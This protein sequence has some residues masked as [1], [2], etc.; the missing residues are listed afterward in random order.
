MKKKMKITFR[1]IISI[2]LS[3]ALVVL[4]FS[5]AQTRSEE[6]RLDE[7]LHLR[8]AVI[9]KS[10]KETIEAF[11][12][13]TEDAG[14][15]Q[16]FVEKFQGHKRLTG[17]IVDLKDK[18]RIALP[19]E[20]A[21]TDLFQKES[22]QTI[23]DN[24]STEV[25]SKWKNSNVYFYSI[26]LVKEGAVVGSLGLI[27]D[28]TFIVNQIRGFWKRS[29][30]TFSILAVILSV[31]TLIVIRWS[32]TGPIARIAELIRKSTG[33]EAP[34]SYTSS[35]EKG[36]IEKLF[37]A[38]THMASSLKAAKLDLAQQSRIIN[39]EGAVWTKERLKDYLQT[40]LLGKKLYVVANREPYIHRKKDGGVE[41]ITPASG[42]VTALDP[43]LQATSGMWFGHGTGDADRETVD[44]DDKLRVPPW[45]P[46]YTLKRVWLTEEEEKGY[47]YG[48]SN[49]GLW[50]LCHISHVRPI[51]R[52]TDWEQYQQVNEKFAASL[53]KE[54]SDDSAPLILIQDYHFAL[55]PKL[56]KE[57]RPD[58]KVALFW[59]IPWPNPEAF[60][61]CPWQE[62]I[63]EG[64]LGSDLIGFHT[65][66]HCNNFLDT[67]DR[68]LEARIDWTNF[69]VIR[70]GRT[71]YVKPFPI[72]VAVSG[73]NSEKEEVIKKLKH[74]LGLEG[75][76]VGLGVDRID[77][78]KGLIER[79]RALERALE[80][81]PHYQGKLVF[82]ELG[83]PSRILIPDYQNH[84][85]NVEA[86]VQ[87]I[88]ERFKSGN[89][90]PIL[91][92][93][94]HHSQDKVRNFYRLAD[95]CLVSSLHDGMNLVAKEFVVAR[96]DEN[97]VLILSRFTGA[98]H[99]FQSSL[100]VNPYDIEGTADA[101]NQALTMLPEEKIERMHKLRQT[102]QEYNVY[103]WAADLITE[104]VKSF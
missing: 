34:G 59:H 83:A 35:A 96:E 16:K 58:A 87:K 27:H 68:A 5:Y 82:I 30:F 63:L 67:I 39:A 57:A 42:V 8:A 77:Y 55:L 53:L 60:G 97:A 51:F 24:V 4:V 54:L 45:K 74:D 44:Q 84:L 78:T 47:Y 75:K 36:E 71:S 79:F 52:M 99:E 89:Y 15:I 6:K 94:E 56:I 23:E 50:P 20:L 13:R 101:I 72:S 73:A 100:L 62:Q 91:F 80:K 19:Q 11:L 46:S 81:Y 9:A 64:M 88:N 76:M 21:E 93:K 103:R 7:E 40:K 98:S 86:L 102:V 18:P 49:E 29:A 22:L 1:L 70:G 90:I 43:V 32:V 17:L 12:E 92:L 28:R 61:I 26:P 65:Q 14:R 104:L 33:S 10:F 25:H 85:Q 37:F 48:F 66:F 2:L 69:G 38:V 41:C 3:T 95:F 31:I